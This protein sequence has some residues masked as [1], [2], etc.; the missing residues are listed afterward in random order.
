MTKTTVDKHFTEWM[1][2]QFK[3]E[4]TPAED[5]DEKV[6]DFHDYIEEKMREAYKAGFKQGYVQCVDKVLNDD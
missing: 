4:W 6:N 2:P 3:G 5:V 1:Y